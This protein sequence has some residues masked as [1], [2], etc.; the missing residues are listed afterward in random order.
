MTDGYEKNNCLSPYQ[1]LFPAGFLF[2]STPN[3]LFPKT[4]LLF[5]NNSSVFLSLKT[6]QP[7][8]KEILIFN[9][10]K[11]L[12]PFHNLCPPFFPFTFPIFPKPSLIVVV[13]V[14]VVGAAFNVGFLYF[15]PFFGIEKKSIYSKHYEGLF[16]ASPSICSYCWAHIVD[17]VAV[18]VVVVDALAAVVV[19]AMKDVNDGDKTAWH[20]V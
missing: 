20:G 13:V 5:S 8:R 1:R 16:R 18:V 17:V 4:V 11:P 3:S 7:P 12:S 15:L 2:S 6:S 19:G 9:P 14:V 10:F